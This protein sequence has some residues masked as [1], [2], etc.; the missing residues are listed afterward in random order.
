MRVPVSAASDYV[1]APAVG[2]VGE[3]TTAAGSAKVC[4][5]AGG[6]LLMT[7]HHSD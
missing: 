4:K 1:L 3:R 6:A 7:K 5:D 2:L